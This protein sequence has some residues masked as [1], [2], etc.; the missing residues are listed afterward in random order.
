MGVNKSYFCSFSFLKRRFRARYAGLH[1]VSKA[2]EK[3][4]GTALSKQPHRFWCVGACRSQQRL[5]VV[6]FDS[7][8]VA[9]LNRS[10]L[11]Y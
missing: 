1:K 10:L 11:L 7:A 4:R 9:C 3:L 5:T 2:S 8:A 6:V